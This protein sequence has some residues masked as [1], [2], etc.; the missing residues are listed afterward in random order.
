MTPVAPLPADVPVAPP[1]GDM[2]HVRYADGDV[3]TW[4]IAEAAARAALRGSDE[5]A[6]RSQEPS[7]AFRGLRAQ[8]VW[9]PHEA[10]EPIARFCACLEDGFDAVE[11]EVQ[12]VV[13][14]WAAQPDPAAARRPEAS[15]WSLQ[16]EGLA[17]KGVWETYELWAHGRRCEHARALLPSTLSLLER[18]AGSAVMLD[19]PGRAYIS[20]LA[21]RTHVKPHSGPTNHRL[22]L[23]LP[24][25]VP[26][27]MPGGPPL[28]ITVAGRLL[29]WERG[30]ALLFDDSFTHSVDFE[31]READAVRVVLVV[32][33]W[34]PQADRWFPVPQ[35]IGLPAEDSESD[36]D[37][38]SPPDS[39]PPLLPDP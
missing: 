22:R 3:E 21:G 30:R 19:P 31:P 27:A 17:T 1:S 23:Q 20:L 16:R 28:G 11:R 6:V 14:A 2:L 25:I 33:L 36:S 12:R 35:R 39:P 18:F 7:F 34:H 5:P 8:P 4:P 38:S 26:A 24:V 9:Q 15:P 32:D 29:P 37:V 13:A 10:G